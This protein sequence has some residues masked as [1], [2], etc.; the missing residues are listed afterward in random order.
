MTA[1]QKSP[2]MTNDSIAIKPPRTAEEIEQLVQDPRYVQIL[3]N[4]QA[5]LDIRR[6]AALSNIDKNSPLLVN[7]WE[8]A[9]GI[10]K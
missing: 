9:S 5:K 1:A 10:S 8:D 2:D 6:A 3:L 4:R 7:I